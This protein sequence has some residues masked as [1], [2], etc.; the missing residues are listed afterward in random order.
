MTDGDRCWI[1][2]A[3][4]SMGKGGG[5]SIVHRVT[6]EGLIEKDILEQNLEWDKVRSYA[7]I[8]R[9]KH[10]KQKEH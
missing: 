8:W 2:K 1:E 3:V 7:D 9:K 6:S 5:A 10:F 4:G